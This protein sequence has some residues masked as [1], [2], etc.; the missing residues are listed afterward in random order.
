MNEPETAQTL[1]TIALAPELGQNHGEFV[2]I[3][4]IEANHG[5]HR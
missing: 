3:L 1:L 2:S 5:F 4:P